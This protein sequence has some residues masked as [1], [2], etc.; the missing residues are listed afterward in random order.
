MYL[1][2]NV[3]LE[4]MLALHKWNDIVAF[5][6][7]AFEVF[8]RLIADRKLKIIRNQALQS[9]DTPEEYSFFFSKQFFGQMFIRCST[10]RNGL[11]YKNH[12]PAE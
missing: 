10:F 11:C 7:A 1:P 2:R 6:L 5:T 9:L 8:F 12:L 3:K 4:V